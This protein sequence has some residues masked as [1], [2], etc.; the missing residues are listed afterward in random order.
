MTDGRTTDDVV[1]V[2]LAAKIDKISEK[3]EITQIFILTS[4]ITTS[5]LKSGS[6][7]RSSKRVEDRAGLSKS[8]LVD[9]DAAGLGS[10]GGFTAI[11]GF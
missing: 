4:E 9:V 5:A 3:R 1:R 11:C 2:F 6:F 10:D 7:F 8:D